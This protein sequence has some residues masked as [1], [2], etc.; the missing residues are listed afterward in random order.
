MQPHPWK[1]L[2]SPSGVTSRRCAL[3]FHKWEVNPGLQEVSLRRQKRIRSR[4]EQHEQTF[5]FPVRPAA[6]G[7]Q[8]LSGTHG[9]PIVSSRSNDAGIRG[10]A[11]SVAFG[12]VAK[13]GELG[14]C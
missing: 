5:D 12:A 1:G 10:A 7:D 8:I 2:S 9:A 4:S 13:P 3:G 11:V 14:S 6:R